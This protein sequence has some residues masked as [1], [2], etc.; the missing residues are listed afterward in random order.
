[1]NSALPRMVQPVSSDARLSLISGVLPIA[2]MMPLR[3]RTGGAFASNSCLTGQPN[4]REGPLQDTGI[5]SKLVSRGF[6]SG[7]QCRTTVAM[8]RATFSAGQADAGAGGS[9]GEETSVPCPGSAST[10]LPA[11]FDTVTSPSRTRTP[12]FSSGPPQNSVPRTPIAATGVETA[13]L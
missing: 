9:R 1:M 8:A 2:S 10:T 7:D 4:E 13:I 6:H 5:P 12:Y 3:G 11:W